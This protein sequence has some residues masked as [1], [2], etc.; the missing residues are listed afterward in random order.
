MDVGSVRRCMAL[1]FL[2]M[3]ASYHAYHRQIDAGIGSE[4]FQGS[5]LGVLGSLYRVYKHRDG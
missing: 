4:A 5:D 1:Y 3:I 2:P